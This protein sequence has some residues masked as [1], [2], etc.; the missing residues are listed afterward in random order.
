M[1]PILSSKQTH[2]DTDDDSVLPIDDDR[3]I[4][5]LRSRGAVVRRESGLRRW[6]L[7]GECPVPGIAKYE[8]PHE[9]DDDY[10]HRMLV[11]LLAV[12]VTL[13]LI[14]AGSWIMTTLMQMTIDSRN[15][16][17]RSTSACAAFYVPSY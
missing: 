9:S 15:C 14:V 1:S 4:I 12:I 6:V 8:H 17:R 13:V 3:N 10:R 5:R 2:S 16:P 11:N 7:T